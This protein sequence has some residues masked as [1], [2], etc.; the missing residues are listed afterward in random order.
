MKERKVCRA[1]LLNVFVGI[2]EGKKVPAI[3]AWC[4]KKK[5]IILEK[6]RK[7]SSSSFYI[8]ERREGKEGRRS[9]LLAKKE[10]RTSGGGIMASPGGRGK[11]PAR[12]LPSEK[13]ERGSKKKTASCPYSFGQR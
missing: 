8:R 4:G 11:R 12:G 2:G 3:L 13:E 9:P 1:T 6:K 7:N 5:K 10:K